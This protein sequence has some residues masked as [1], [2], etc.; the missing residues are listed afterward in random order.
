MAEKESFNE[1]RNNKRLAKN[2]LLLYA[3]MLLIMGISLYTSRIILNALGVEDYGIYNV[4]GGVVAMFSMLSGSLSS[5]ISR[6]ITFELGCGNKEALNRVFSS[7]IMIQLGLSIIILVLAETIGLWFINNKMIIPETRMIAANWVYQLSLIT[8]VINLLSIPYNAVII[9]HENMSAFAYISIF[10]AIGKLAVAFLVIMSPI[11]KLVF[12]AALLT[13]ISLITRLL[14][15][16]YCKKHFEECTLGYTYDHNLFKRLFRFAGWNFIGSSSALLRDQGGNILINLFFGPTVNT[17]RG[18]AQ[19][20]S[21][22][23]YSF[24]QNFMIALNPQITKSFAIGN[25]EYMMTLLF[26][27][28]RFSYYMLLLLSIPVLINT[29]YILN[30]WL[31]TVPQYTIIFVQLIIIFGLSE[32]LSGPLITAMLATGNIRNYQIAVGGIQLMN[33]PISYALLHIGLM[34][35]ITIIVAII[36]SQICL[37]LR[38]FFLRKMIGLPPGQFIR[39]VY[40]NVG[41]VTF[42]SVVIPIVLSRYMTENFGNFLL[43]CLVSVVVTLL[44]EFFIGCNQKERQFI[45]SKILAKMYKNI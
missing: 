22:A 30:L 42:I 7:S 32:A 23:L 43:I 16:Y 26:Q 4:V 5:A 34:P 17:A 9:A 35:Q 13:G 36:L 3:R 6:F 41:K 1:Y 44:T 18:I 40:L 39:K 25:N 15:G 2:T 29:P 45:V 8:F 11:D 37:A 31:D 28:A 27:G 21:T 12:Y 33:L 20:V 10:E 24:V 19:Q 14:Y 38:L